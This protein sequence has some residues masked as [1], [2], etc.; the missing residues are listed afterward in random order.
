[1]LA[2]G[3][4]TRFTISMPLYIDG[5]R[6]GDPII[7]GY[8]G[9][10]PDTVLD[11]LLASHTT[12]A[13]YLGSEE[14]EQVERGWP[15]CRINDPS[16]WIV[17]TVAR[18]RHGRPVAVSTLDG[19]RRDVGEACH[20]RYAHREQ[21]PHPQVALAFAAAAPTYAMAEDVLHQHAIASPRPDPQI[22]PQSYTDVEI[23]R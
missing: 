8:G 20:Y 5:V 18:V 19:R 4:M 23:D 14:R 16:E 11:K 17:G 1:M 9:D 15:K 3:A 2:V 6:R 10:H 22:N 12:I 7:V 13:P 21:I